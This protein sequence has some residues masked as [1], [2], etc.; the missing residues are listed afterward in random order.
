MTGH[1]REPDDEQRLLRRRRVL[2]AAGVGLT[3]AIAGCG[4][5]DNG[6]G[7]ESDEDD[8]PEPD[9]PEPDDDAN[10]TDD[11]TDDDGSDEEEDDGPERS[12]A[13]TLLNIRDTL[14]SDEPLF[15]PGAE[16]FSGD[17]AAVTDEISLVPALTVIAFD[18]D[19]DANFIVEL[20]GPVDDL[21]VN[22]IGPTTGAAGV[23]TD[24]G[25][26]LF[27][28]DADGD[29]SMMVGQPIAPPEQIR[30]PSVS[31]DGDG[32]AVVGPVELDETTTFT[33][34]HMSDDGNFIIEVYN[35]ETSGGFADELVFNE[36]G[37]F[38]GETRVDPAGVAW[39]DV[40]ADGAWRLEI[41]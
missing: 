6:D 18:H 36:I 37:E 8:D 25:D 20:E 23:A 32:P 24:R 13:D 35:E 1:H 7:A 21:V 27:D 28:V 30:T 39:I 29:W 26:Y 31:A 2:G 19:G 17:S 40:E 15:D 22:A 3:A 9:D 10:D 4:S 41:S 16:T 33:G 12:D 11:A 5:S 34:E 14:D 38:E